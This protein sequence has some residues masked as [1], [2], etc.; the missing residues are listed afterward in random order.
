VPLIEEARPGR[1]VTVIRARS[2]GGTA[3][4]PIL[5]HHRL[6]P[7]P[8]AALPLLPPHVFGR[9]RAGAFPLRFTPF[10][11]YYIG[12]TVA[13]CRRYVSGW[14]CWRSH[15]LAPDPRAALPLL[16]PHLL[17]RRCAGMLGF[18]LLECSLS[19]LLCFRLDFIGALGDLGDI[20]AVGAVGALTDSLRI[21]A[22]PFLSYPLTSSE[23]AAQAC[24]WGW[25]Y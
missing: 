9:R 11:L 8:R 12:A 18:E 15:R 21:L 5:R 14:R 25:R 6:A 1:P 3:G 23:G 17:G 24:S 13:V 16:P 22:P 19:A 4:I 2:A 7:H 20:C 10:S